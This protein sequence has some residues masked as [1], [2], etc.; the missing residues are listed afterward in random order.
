MLNAE[1]PEVAVV[2]GYGDWWY[3]TCINKGME[4]ALTVNADYILTLN[5]DIIFDEKYVA[6]LMTVI[7]CQKEP[8]MVGSVSYT[9]S[10]PHRI[11]FSGI[12]RIIRW[13]LKEINYISKFSVA[14]PASHSGYLRS[15]NL[16]GRGIIFPA[17]LIK[18]LGIYDEKLIQYGSDTDF[19]YRAVKA[20]INVFISYDAVV[21]ENE[22][23]TSK[24]AS[25][26]KTGIKEYWR[27]L[28]DKH[29]SNSIRNGLYF[30]WKHGFKILIP[31]YLF[32]IILGAFYNLF[33]KYR[34]L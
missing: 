9:Q 22:K 21:F 8:C 26:N 29:S 20:G 28:F 32:I 15:M 13:R 5:D 10:A 3:T 31:L 17:V 30:Y 16:S 7:E 12:R 1:F 14:D 6:T 33:F 18:K 27:S 24:G 2:N 19:S 23:L 25:Y 4:Q 11:S 34:N